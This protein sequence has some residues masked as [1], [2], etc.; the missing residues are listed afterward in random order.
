MS[1]MKKNNL[2]WI[3]I[4]GLM[5]VSF[6]CKNQNAEEEARRRADS[7]AMEQARADSI[8][9]ITDSLKQVEM[10][11]ERA[12]MAEVEAQQRLKFHVIKGSFVY[13]DNADRFLEVQR[14][15]FPA[16]KQ[17]VAPNGFKLVSIAD[18]ASMEEAVSYVNRNRGG[19]EDELWV[20]EEGGRYDTSGYLNSDAYSSHRSK[21]D[22][23]ETSS[24]TSTPSAS[25]TPSTPSAPGAD[26][27]VVVF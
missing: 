15:S 24:S 14:G 26:P 25:S 5:A 16:A 9:R 20:F 6:G 12:R 27:D 7:I 11:R 18:F 19:E 8:L 3:G 4:V 10:E 23:N 17:F 22:G 2:L 1:K 13:Q 21:M